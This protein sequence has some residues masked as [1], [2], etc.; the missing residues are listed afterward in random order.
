MVT[1]RQ[2]QSTGQKLG[3]S[4]LSAMRGGIFFIPALLILSRIRGLAGIQEAQP[5]AYVLAFIPS[6]FFALWFFKKLPPE[7]KPNM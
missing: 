3:A 2:L 5:L 7:D 4:L 1:E 6:I